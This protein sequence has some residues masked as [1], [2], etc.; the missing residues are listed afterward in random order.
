M[1]EQRE[2]GCG[3][4]Y[5]W[6][7]QKIPMRDKDTFECEVCGERLASWNSSRIQ[8]F[9]LIHD[10]RLGGGTNPAPEGAN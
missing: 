4:I 6:W 9:D 7:E 1:K 2:C 5:E 10:P 3:A 8:R